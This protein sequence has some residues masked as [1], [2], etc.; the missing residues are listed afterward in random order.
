MVGHFP[1]GLFVC[2]GDVRGAVTAG[3]GAAIVGFVRIGVLRRLVVD[4][5][6]ILADGW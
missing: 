2:T 4:G 6:Q 5:R 3:G 1:E